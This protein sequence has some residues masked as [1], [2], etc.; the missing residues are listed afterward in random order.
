MYMNCHVP[1]NMTDGKEVK[2]FG[3]WKDPLLGFQ[4]CFDYL[5]PI[6]QDDGV[7]ILM[8]SYDFSYMDELSEELVKCHCKDEKGQIGKV[9]VSL[10]LQE[11]GRNEPLFHLKHSSDG[12]EKIKIHM[13]DPK[14]K[15]DLVCDVD[16]AKG[17][18]I[19]HVDSMS[20][21]LSNFDQF[22]SHFYIFK[23]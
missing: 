20:D 23:F 14:P 12:R 8:D 17:M 7:L 16:L 2:T 1:V 10:L 3:N 21:F 11:L 5:S 18:F 6:G 13:T 9:A 19:N 15:Q 22:K 4:E